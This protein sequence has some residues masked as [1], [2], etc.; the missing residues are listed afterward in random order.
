MG[1]FMFPFQVAML[2]NFEDV[3]LYDT[4]TLRLVYAG[5]SKLYKKDVERF[6]KRFP[7]TFIVEVI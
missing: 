6:R 2:S 3:S 7:F 1:L 5:G 4:S